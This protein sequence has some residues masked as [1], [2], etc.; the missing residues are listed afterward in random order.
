M[1]AFSPNLTG[2]TRVERARAALLSCAAL[3]MMAT[4]AAAQNNAEQPAE[5][6][7][8]A[9]IKVCETEQA[10][11]REAC[12]V[13]QEIRDP[14]G[15][16]LATAGVRTHKDDP[17]SIA[18]VFGFPLGMLLQPGV[19]YQVD[20]GEQK[21]GEFGICLPTGC[22]AE[23]KATAADV[24][25]FKKGNELI[26]LAISG[27]G[28]TVPFRLSLK[29][30]T[31][32]FDGPPIDPKVLAESQRKLQAEIQRRAEERRKK[33]QEQQQSQGGGSETAPAENSQ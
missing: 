27:R 33:L 12:V 1:S 5:G 18:L 30:F 7:G 8:S 15:T 2:K 23:I 9:W 28:E 4:S 19:R 16:F 22:F 25:A 6:S 29:G 26:L 20:Q 17:E 13:T 31:K 14:Q 32:T 21:S 11:G 3:A 24:N 10:S